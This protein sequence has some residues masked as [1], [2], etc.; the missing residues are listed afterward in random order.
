MILDVRK[1]D[2]SLENFEERRRARNFKSRIERGLQTV[3]I[4]Q[5]IGSVGRSLD[6]DNNFSLKSRHSTARLESIKEAMKKQEPLPPVQLYKMGD[7]YYVVDGHHRIAGA[8]ELG[9]KFIDASVIEYLPPA[10]SEHG[11]V[12]RR[13]VDFE[14]RTGLQE[15]QLSRADSY[16]K[17]LTQIEEHKKHLEREEGRGFSFEEAAVDWF[18]AIYYPITEKIKEENL[19]QYLPDATVGDIYVYLC[20]QIKLLRNQEEDEYKVE[21]EEAL[22]EFSILRKATELLFE[23]GLTE[24][25][26]NKLLRL[27]LPSVLLYGTTAV[28]C[29]PG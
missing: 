28:F 16:D 15:I 25:L 4:E 1:N 27:F 22:E 2:E 12:A 19:S 5:I 9:Q 13:R 24:G 29:S 20:D 14:N 23:E 8:K 17:L 21:L 11:L 6:F 7:E 3:P 18:Y 26:K 10:N